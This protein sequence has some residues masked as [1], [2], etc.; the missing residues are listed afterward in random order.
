MLRVFATE[1]IP[2]A[3]T[4]LLLAAA[5]IIVQVLTGAKGYPT[6]PPGA[7]ILLAAAG[8]V[9]ITQR[10]WW[11][12]LIAVALAL[13]ISFGAIVT[14]G[15]AYRL[16]RPDELGPFIGTVVQLVGLAVA[17][18]AGIAETTQKL[19]ASRHR[20]DER[21]SGIGHDGHPTVADQVAR[22]KFVALPKEGRAF[23]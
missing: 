1:R 5:G 19:K 9:A 12:T 13:L 7:V 23:S 22:E 8:L 2:V 3:A 4:G 21:A 17:L 6:I 18:I 16:G 10:W 11:S 14:R 20:P 15:R